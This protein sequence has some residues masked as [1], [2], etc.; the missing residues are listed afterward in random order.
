MLG[1]PSFH[2]LVWISEV[3][4]PRGSLAGEPCMLQLLWA[5]RVTGGLERRSADARNATVLDRSLA[6]QR[7]PTR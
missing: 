3:R 6:D 7:R 1:A 5:G 2:Y 4:N